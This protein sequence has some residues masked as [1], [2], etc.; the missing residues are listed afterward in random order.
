MTASPLEYPPHVLRDYALLADGERGALCGP[1]GDVGWLCATGWDDEAVFSTLVGGAG[2]YAVTPAGRAY[3]WGGWY[4][5]GTLIWRSHW[6][7]TETMLEC[8]DALAYPGDPGR[9]VLLRRVEADTEPARVTVLLDPHAN[10][11]T[12]SLR[13]L[14]RDRDGRWTARTGDLLLRWTGGTGAK[15]RDGRLVLDLTVPA[16]RHHDLVLEISDR[17]L[18]DP[19]DA[20]RAWAATENS[21]IHAVPEFGDSVAPRDTRHAYAVLQGLTSSGGGMVA[22]AT[23]GLPERAEAGRNYDYRY[24]WLRDQCYAGIAAAVDEP[25]PL[26]DTATGF[27]A[28]QVLTHG[29]KLAPAYRVDGATLPAETRVDIPGYPGGDDIV[30]NRVTG[31]F[32]VDV[33]GELLQLFAAAARHDR[34]DTDGLAAARTVT[35][36][37]EERWNQPDAGIWEL[38][39]AWWTHSRLACV[40]GLRAMAAR[41]PRGEGARLDGLADTILAETSRRCLRPD[42]AWRR[43]PDHDG[44]DAALVLPPVRGAL[45]ATDP[46]TVATRR[47]V[48]TEL[49]RDGYLYRFAADDRPLGQAEGAFLLCGFTMALAAHHAGETTEAFRW[50]ERTRAACGPPGLFAEEWDVDQRQLR[51]NLPQAFVHAAMLESGQRL[52][53][54]AGGGGAAEIEVR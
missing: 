47:A 18:P 54:P 31:Q 9:I 39:D 15:V 34:L 36:L 22:A 19:P 43:S 10:F 6:V 14:H 45:P 13:D 3:V 35:R 40:G 53:G 1:R 50:F 8:R 37:V 12:R 32:Q 20:D 52:A 26:L 21:W 23:L 41:L 46:R 33:L 16:G 51:G 4:E 49:A 44:T 48:R 17:T 42:G 29:D 7:T 25:H 2:V 27:T 38:D 11:G 30:G 28:A 24:V 5:P